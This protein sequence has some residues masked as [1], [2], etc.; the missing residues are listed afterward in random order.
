MINETYEGECQT[1]RQVSAAQRTARVL[2]ACAAAVLLLAAG[3]AFAAECTAA[4]ARVVSVQ[5]TVELRRGPSTSWSA[6]AVEVELCP[7]DSLR[8]GERSRAALR[9]ANDSTVRLDQFTALTLGAAQERAS[10]ID[11]LRGAINIITRTPK[12]FDVRTPFLNAGVEGT[13]FLVRVDA[14]MAQVAVY[15]GRVSVTNKY[16]ALALASGEVALAAGDTLL[17]R[18][19]IVRPSR[20]VQWALHYPSIIGAGGTEAAPL[21]EA[22]SLSRSGRISDAF[23]RLDAVPT[24]ARDARHAVYRAELLL[25][26]GRV[27]DARTEIARALA[28]DARS[29]DSYALQAIIAVVQ[30]EGAEAQRLADTAVELDSRSAAA[31]LSLSHVEQARFDIASAL[32]S[33]KQAAE[34]VPD[35][36][37]A[38]ARVAELLMANGDLGAALVAAQRAASLEPGLSRAQTLLGFA[39]LTRI[40]T[41]AARQAFSRAIGLDQSDPLPHLGLGLAQVRD[42]ELAAG[43]E[44][45]EIAV[46]L[47]P[48]NSLARSYMGKAYHEEKRDA[49][50]GSQL[51]LAKAQD[52]LDPTPYFYDAIRKQAANL[53]VEALLDLNRSVDLND[54][55]AVYRSRLLLDD[56]N[57]ARMA[58]IAAIYGELGFEKL[59]ALES[60]K[61]LAANV[62]NDAAHR[63]L[64][65]AYAGLPRHD[66]A[67]ISESLQ[68]QLRQPLSAAP[69]DP[70]VGTG[71]LVVLTDAGPT[72]LGASEY[73]AL[74][75]RDQVRVQVDGVSGSRGT[76]ADQFVISGLAGRLA[77]SASR[78]HFA[79]DGFGESGRLDKRTSD[80]FVQGDLSPTVSI[81]I[82]L[83]RVD[84]QLGQTY[85][86]FD[87]S[88]VF[89]VK[90]GEENKAYRLGGRAS[91]T[92]SDWIWS[93]FREGR[94]RTTVAAQDDFL[95]TTTSTVTRAAELQHTRKL[96]GGWIAAGAARVNAMDTFPIEQADAKTTAT[97]LYLYSQWPAGKLPLTLLLGLSYD[98]FKLANT[99]FPEP[100]V[101]R[102]F[103]PKLGLVWTAAPG[104]TLRTSITSSVKRPF[105]GSQ[106]LEPTQVAGFN[107]FF[108]G[109][110]ALFGDSDGTLSRRAALAI[111]HRLDHR[112]FVGAEVANRQ[113]RV[114][115]FN[116]GEARWRER[117]LRGYFYRTLDAQ[118]LPGW[119]VAVT[120]EFDDE[121]IA[122]PQLLPGPEGIVDVRTVR[123]PLG[124]RS[125]HESGLAFSATASYVK[126]YG[127]FAVDINSSAFAK[128][129]SAWIAD[130]S[131][132]YRLPLRRGQ[133]SFGVRNVFDSPISI[134]ETDPV[135]PRVAKRR[136][137]FGKLRLNF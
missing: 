131:M 120:A 123:V 54:N 105:V 77:W 76:A 23:A 15:E 109:F 124:V 92:A 132:D 58:S 113:M 38:W 16:G 73:N 86:A 17:R 42:G 78:Q 39:H 3:R 101:R 31:R 95:L 80:I 49:L 118:L 34:V 90:I 26:V 94:S 9:L 68:A 137:V 57:A 43:R 88:L 89:P 59:A 20:A 66:I 60:V 135:N 11:L 71:S 107:Q 103:N 130:I 136:L 4:A 79:T 8:V 108:T 91:G 33:A 28:L 111:D 134:L 51:A 36:G 69:V 96:A 13:E 117:G 129:D 56:D 122:R 106:T 63:Q 121:E 19:P 62:G 114:P 61:A 50:A 55:R 53:P 104:T 83:R 110:D 65:A 84:F 85:F 125:F 98:H 7:G 45:I 112:T 99:L 82:D 46:S 87:P 115:N 97:V 116:V 21:R 48:L 127:L 12:P 14:E 128:S 24:E 75:S 6:A 10:L 72:R 27:E 64:A 32:A 5:G 102:R 22:H 126:Q 30:N 93:I 35:N 133:L 2:A 74:F 41:A 70:R 18:E 52:P 119:Q 1:R 81:Q 67:R 47:D 100:I 37:L 25:L 29:S 40:Q 44:E